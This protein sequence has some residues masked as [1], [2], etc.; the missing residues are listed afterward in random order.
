MRIHSQVLTTLSR[1]RALRQ[2]RSRAIIQS[3]RT[4]SNTNRLSSTNK[5]N[6]IFSKINNYQNGLKSSQLI[7]DYSTIYSSCE[8]L[9]NAS[10]KLLSTKDDSIFNLAI[11]ENKEQTGKTDNKEKVISQIKSV[12]NQFNTV[13]EKMNDIGYT[14]NTLYRKQ[15]SQY[16]AQS[17]TD[18][19]NLGIT[20]EKD[21]TLSIDEK[22]LNA[23]D[24][25][26]LQDVFGKKNSFMNRVAVRI[27]SISA[28]ANSN[29]SLQLQN[30][31]TSAY[32]K[33][34]ES[35]ENG[36]GGTGHYFSA[37]R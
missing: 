12:V 13:M 6:A 10:D 9:L 16:V 27:E 4:N 22:V 31:Y 2:A 17:K 1:N 5:N 8:S 20:E 21:G 14:V 35:T 37:S 26:K 24:L 36:Y 18:L 32:S 34:G 30:G 28:Y 15:L 19:K 33:F 7:K 25:S 3:G 23:A 11:K 29:V